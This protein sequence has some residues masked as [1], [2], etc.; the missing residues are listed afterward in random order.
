MDSP[1]S[2]SRKQVPL[3]TAHAYVE[4]GL[5]VIPLCPPDHAGMWPR[6]CQDCRSPGKAPWV[7]DWPS[8]RVPTAEELSDWARRIPASNL[9]LVLGA[10]SGLVGVDPDGETGEALLSEWSGGDLPET[11]EFRT[12]AGRRLLYRIPAGVTLKKTRRRAGAGHEELALLG[13]GQQTVLPPSV[14][15]SGAI[16]LWAPGRDPWTFGEA[17][18][19]PAWMVAR[20]RAREEAKRTTARAPASSGAGP[21]A[22][23]LDELLDW[24]LARAA[25]LPRNETGFD[26]ACQLRDAGASTSQAEDVLLRYAAAVEAL[27]DHP[28]T[29]DEA[30]HSLEQAYSGARREPWRAAV[31]PIPPR[32]L[33]PRNGARPSAVVSRERLIDTIAPLRVLRT[34]PPFYTA[35]IRGAGLDL[36]LAELTAFQAFKRKCVAALDFMPRLPARWDDNHRR[37]SRDE[38]WEE[39]VD[40]ALAELV[41]D[42]PP[43]LDA[44]LSGVIWDAVCQL[45]TRGTARSERRE[46]VP[47]GQAFASATHVVIKGDAVRELL[48]RRGLDLLTPDQLW[49]VMRQHGVTSGSFYVSATESERVWK[50]ANGI[51]ER[52]RGPVEWDG[53]TPPV[54]EMGLL[55]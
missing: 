3:D 23:H 7:Q 44:S 49:K 42:E 26:L 12:G 19:A 39:I 24:A 47:M 54:E 37:M 22:P 8:R 5:P 45:L 35:T 10:A 40:Q 33:S 6:H 14:H 50:F 34:D 32:E 48:R 55:T 18:L 13:E 16:Y 17:T 27:G 21:D 41:E 30:R 9:G 20:M 11:W 29:E 31:L 43:P 25:A 53:E 4:L 52:E 15:P 51:L 38:V 2:T 36:T 28:Y 1:A 46:D